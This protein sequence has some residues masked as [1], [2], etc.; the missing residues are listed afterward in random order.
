MEV[1]EYLFYGTVVLSVLNTLTK[2]YF[3]IDVLFFKVEPLFGNG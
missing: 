1:I 3:R 2:K